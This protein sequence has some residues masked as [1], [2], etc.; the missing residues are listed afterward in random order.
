MLV[1]SMPFENQNPLTKVMACLPFYLKN[2]D[3]T[4]LPI[5]PSSFYKI[6]NV[7]DVKDFKKLLNHKAVLSF[8]AFHF[9]FSLNSMFYFCNNENYILPYSPVDFYTYTCFNV[10]A[11][12]FIVNKMK[13]ILNKCF[14]ILPREVR[15]LYIQ[16]PKHLLDYKQLLQ[17]AYSQKLYKFYK[18][19]YKI[20]IEFVDYEKI[21][22]V[23]F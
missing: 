20:N 4:T 17:D 23:K 7:E 9:Y 19:H 14:S 3:L 10:E 12:E 18:K 15:I 5:E 2:E 1:I 11:P 8:V 13:D 6:F 16:L 22:N 21:I